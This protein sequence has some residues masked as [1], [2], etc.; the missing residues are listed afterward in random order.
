MFILIQ[1]KGNKV[2]NSTPNP[3]PKSKH[4]LKTTRKTAKAQDNSRKLF[5]SQHQQE[6]VHHH[7]L[8][9]K[10]RKKKSAS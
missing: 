9:P 10:R 7:H 5:H 4:D 8:N 3:S 6:A 2:L 1:R